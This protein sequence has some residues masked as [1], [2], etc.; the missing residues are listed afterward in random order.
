MKRLFTTWS[1]LAACLL[2]SNAM[3][4]SPYWTPEERTSGTLA[5]YFDDEMAEPPVAEEV[6]GHEHDA[7]ASDC[8]AE[9]DGCAEAAD[10]ACAEEAS[11]E[12]GEE[13]A[14]GDECGNGCGDACSANG[15]LCSGW[16]LC[17][18]CPGDAW[19]MQKWLTPCNDDITYA[20]WIQMGYH[21][22]TTGLSANEGD[23]LDFNDVPDNVNLQQMWMYLE[24]ATEAD[25]CSADWGYR[26]D[27]VYGTDAQKTQAFG[28][29]P[30]GANADGWD[31]DWDHG[32][33][34]WALPQA[35]AEVAFGDWKVKGGHFFTPIGYEVV[36]A[37]GNF[38]YSHALTM[39]NSE[40]FTHT[41]VLGTYSGIED[42]TIYTGWVLGWDTGYDQF[43]NG[44]AFLGGA[45]RSMYD[46]DLTLTY[47][48][49]IGNLGFRSNDEFGYSH[50]I[51]GIANLS[52]DYQYV[53]QHDLVAADGLLGLDQDNFDVGVN[54]YL[55]RTLNDCWKIGGRF[56]WWSTDQ[57]TPGENISF[58]EIT[59]GI[60]Y[61][62]HANVI[63]RP[64]I[65]YDFTS[66]EEAVEVAQGREY[67]R[68]EFGIDVIFTF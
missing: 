50:S 67:D 41:G 61:R 53:L 65:R 9:S 46:G 20:G 4:E 62:P 14:C 25:A 2:A 13:A 44:N 29:P 42:Y 39:F 64:E 45:T 34:G 31:N 48:C 24:K 10:C 19:T 15:D 38:F 60:N 27:A 33:Y 68:E 16:S 17:N 63:V 36:P 55:F 22:E 52:E 54:Q 43:G 56:E 26:V 40:P 11:C 18:C 59:G 8:Y 23:L 6:V 66:D 28:N 21:S 49:T 57:L 51:V 35:Y 12:C 1:A 7:V 32:V 47:L 37:T 5:A 30:G 3:A 58:F